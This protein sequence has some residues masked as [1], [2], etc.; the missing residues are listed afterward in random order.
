MP[1]H[2]LHVISTSHALLPFIIY[3]WF[4][5]EIQKSFKKNSLYKKKITTGIGHIKVGSNGINQQDQNHINAQIIFTSCLT[6]YIH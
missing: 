6:S 1:A 2:N 5:Q 4:K 3:K